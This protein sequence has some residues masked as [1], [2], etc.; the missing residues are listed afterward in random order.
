MCGNPIHRVELVLFTH[1]SDV[2]HNGKK[3]CYM[4]GFCDNWSC[5][6]D[7]P[8]DDDNWPICDCEMENYED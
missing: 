1:P 4:D 3:M 2:R 5:E 7:H 8:L 6:C